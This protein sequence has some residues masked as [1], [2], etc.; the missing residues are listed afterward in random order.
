MMKRSVENLNKLLSDYQVF[1]QK[2]R[3]YHWNVTGPMF[4]QLHARFEEL[5]NATAETADEVAERVRMLGDRPPSTYKEQLAMA[6]LKEDESVPA[7]PAMVEA[8]LADYRS[9]N[10]WLREASAQAGE[11]G[12]RATANLLEGIAD[13]QEKTIWMLESFTGES[14]A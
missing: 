9:L 4:Y 5:Y 7:A 14:A 10:G 11:D 2:L 8:V 3:N 1:Y 12:D 6:R 13:G